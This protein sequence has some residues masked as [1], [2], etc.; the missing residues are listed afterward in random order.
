[1]ADLF[2]FSAD[3]SVTPSGY[4]SSVTEIPTE[5]HS[6]VSA[7]LSVNPPSMLK[8]FRNNAVAAAAYPEKSSKIT[9]QDSLVS[10]DPTVTY[11]PSELGLENLRKIATAAPENARNN[12][13]RSWERSGRLDAE[14]G[15]LPTYSPQ[16]HSLF[17]EDLNLY[18]QQQR[19]LVQQQDLAPQDL[20]QQEERVPS[21]LRDS[22][23]QL[24]PLQEGVTPCLPKLVASVHSLSKR[25]KIQL[26]VRSFKV[27]DE[28][29]FK[30]PIVSVPSS[31]ASVM[32]DFVKCK[33]TTGLLFKDKGIVNVPDFE[34][35]LD[36]NFDD[37][38]LLTL[39]FL[40]LRGR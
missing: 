5:Q 19:H 24:Q 23:M 40:A 21:L 27:N 31:C 35:F 11:P 30:T 16:Q 36:E 25:E 33:Y 4:H 37:R 34:K 22:R 7:D 8:F 10:A 32:R 3:A 12:F 18:W 39:I 26:L 1:M 38:I 28:S 29:R 20:L 15:P 2:S 13:W 17:W 9:E 14:S 6:L